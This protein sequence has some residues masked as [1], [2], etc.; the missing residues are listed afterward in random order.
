MKLTIV[1]QDFAAGQGVDYVTAITARMFARIGWDVDVVVS[2]VHADYLKEG[3][4]AFELP[5]TAKLIYMPSRRSR[6]NVLFLRKYLRKCKSDYVIAEPVQ[7]AW[8][9]RLAAIGTR[10]T[11]IPKLVEVN[12]NNVYLLKGVRLLIMRLKYWF[13]YSKFHSLFF[14]NAKSGENFKAMFGFL[15]KLRL[16][17]VNNPCL[18][19]V[20]KTKFAHAP[21][22]P[23]LIDKKCM[24]FVSAGAYQPYKCHM[25]ILKALCKVR[26]LGCQVRVIIFGRG[27]LEPEYRRFIAEN[28]LDEYVSLGGF[29][30]QLPAEIRA[31]DGFILSTNV[32]TFGIVLVEGLACG[33]PCISTDAPFGPREILADGKYGRIVPVNDV[34]AMA[35]ALIDCIEG[36]V[37]VA[38]SNAWERY[39]EDAIM[40]RYLK[41]LGLDA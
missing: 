10:K 24:T 7:Y 9:I 4:K 36:N 8:C 22:H 17:S 26:D 35:K 37:P 23:W 19:D 13:L 30:N 27:P 29:T 3:K 20:F 15:N 28:H 38:P 41:G 34:D 6:Y 33:V 12:H 5:V 18:D 32:E 16:M 21:R 1:G 40:H 31:S 2:Q 25:L 14:V 11:K 39:T